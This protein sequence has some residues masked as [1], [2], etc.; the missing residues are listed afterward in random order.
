LLSTFRVRLGSL[1]LQKLYGDL[2]SEDC[3]RRARLRTFRPT[4]AHAPS[5]STNRQLLFL[6]VKGTAARLLAYLATPRFLLLLSFVYEVLLGVFV[7]A[8]PAEPAPRQV[9]DLDQKKAISVMSPVWVDTEVRT[10]FAGGAVGSHMRTNAETFP[11]AIPVSPV[12][13]LRVVIEVL[14]AGSWITQPVG[15]GVVGTVMVLAPAWRTICVTWPFA[16]A[17]A[18]TIEKV[19]APVGSPEIVPEIVTLAVAATYLPGGG[20]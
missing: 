9:N 8:D 19:R 17:D 20:S 12:T 6:P 1:L 13:P 4:S 18:V 2:L 7:K 10:K 15:A 16:A 3:F 5:A 14:V 11:I